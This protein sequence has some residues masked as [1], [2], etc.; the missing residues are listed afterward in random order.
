MPD[1]QYRAV[2]LVEHAGGVG[3][4][5]DQAAQRIGRGDDGIALPLQL[6]DDAVP[7]GRIGEG[8]VHQHDRRLDA[9]LLVCGIHRGTS[10]V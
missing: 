10:C 4:I 1:E 7:A 3:G 8:A 5:G 2:D 9:S 6:L